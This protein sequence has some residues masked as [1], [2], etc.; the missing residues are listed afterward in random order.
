MISLK[1]ILVAYKVMNYEVV[2]FTTL[3]FLVYHHLHKKEI[4]KRE[5]DFSNYLNSNL[6]FKYQYYENQKT[7]SLTKNLLL[8]LLVFNS[9]GMLSSLMLESFSAHPDFHTAINLTIFVLS[10]LKMMSILF[11]FTSNEPKMK[12]SFINL[13][14]LRGKRYSD[15]ENNIAVYVS[16]NSLKSVNNEQIYF[17]GYR[18]QWN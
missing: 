4:R 10:V 13:F 18:R 16:S 5:N 1:G 17:Y 8:I 2:I 7:Y 6:S 14:N 11:V 12:L 9:L 15:D 3:A